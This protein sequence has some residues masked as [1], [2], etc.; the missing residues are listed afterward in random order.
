MWIQ[1][2]GRLNLPIN[3]NTRICS[4]HFVSVAKRKLRPDEY[5]T[6]SSLVRNHTTTTKLRR[7]PTVRT[8]PESLSE[9]SD[10]EASV[11]VE[12]TTKSVAIQA[13]NG[14]LEV[15]EN[16]KGTV[17]QLKADATALKFC[18][19]NSAKDEQLV[20]FYTGFPSYASLKSCYDYL[21]PTV[22]NL[23]YWGSKDKDVGHGR[24]RVLSSFNEFFGV[25]SPKVRIVRTRSC[26][27]FQ[28]FSIHS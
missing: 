18:I 10:E 8:I 27:T 14:S 4:D 28:Y 20:T 1:K 19:E 26:L 9:D 25:S 17:T 22:D 11:F 3:A 2:I 24:S 5:P 12:G 23:M 16:L 13:C 21:G 6:L 7:P 15:I